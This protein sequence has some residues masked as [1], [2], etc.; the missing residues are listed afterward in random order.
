MKD[1]LP[2]DD[3]GRGACLGCC[4]KRKW[5]QK[6]K[7]IIGR[8]SFYRIVVY[9]NLNEWRL[10]DIIDIQDGSNSFV[11]KDVVCHSTSQLGLVSGGLVY[12]QQVNIEKNIGQWGLHAN[13]CETKRKV[14]TPKS[15]ISTSL[16]HQPPIIPFSDFDLIKR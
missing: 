11:I 3:L 9:K 5:C 6:V 13:W 8:I 15:T 16:N 14:C 4:G 10:N 12:T 7:T 2:L 1:Y